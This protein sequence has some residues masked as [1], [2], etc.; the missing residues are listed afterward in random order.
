MRQED[1]GGSHVHQKRIPIHHGLRSNLDD[2][3]A[4]HISWNPDGVIP[5]S[6]MN[7]V[8][9]MKHSVRVVLTLVSF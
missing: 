8:H 9:L 4:S 6:G 2:Q 5:Q 1:E 3:I 7:Q